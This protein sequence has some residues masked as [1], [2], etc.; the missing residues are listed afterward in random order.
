MPITQGR[1]LSLITAALDYQQAYDTLSRAVSD[2]WNRSRTAPD[3]DFNSTIYAEFQ[4][5]SLL[6]N[7]AAALR[8]HAGS[9][10]AI[11][12]EHQHFKSFAARNRAE[13]IRQARRRG[14][15][16][17]PPPVPLDFHR[18]GSPYDN[19]P[20]TLTPANQSTRRTIHELTQAELARPR[21]TPD[22]DPRITA[23]DLARFNAQVEEDRKRDAGFSLDFALAPAPAKLD[24]D[25]MAEIEA[26]AEREIARQQHE[27]RSA[28][29]ARQGKQ[30]ISEEPEV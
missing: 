6:T 22:I 30:E 11:A 23:E 2:S 12:T 5:A 25:I 27:A 28:E 1:M 15:L 18:T 16:P 10:V 9:A 26:E 19:A 17:N 13:A 8:D 21:Q 3:T 20:Q 29:L 24:N 14:R 7:P 4:N